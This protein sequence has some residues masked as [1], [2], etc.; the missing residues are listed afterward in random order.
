MGSFEDSKEHKCLYNTHFGPIY[1]KNLG[2]QK[3]MYLVEN[4]SQIH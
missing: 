1:K 2:Q 3:L 4:L